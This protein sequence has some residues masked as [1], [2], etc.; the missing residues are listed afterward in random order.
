MA[1]R[2]GGMG[3]RSSRTYA[4][5]VE[6][7]ENYFAVEFNLAPHVGGHAMARKN[8]MAHAKRSC[9]TSVYRHHS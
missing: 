9:T 3:E 2:N 1:N 6:K 8:M 4:L 5:Q 7:E